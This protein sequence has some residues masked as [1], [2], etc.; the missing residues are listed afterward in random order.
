LNSYV[1][2]I[3]ISAAV[4]SPL[5]LNVYV[6]STISDI[7]HTKNTRTQESLGY[8]PGTSYIPQPS[9]VSFIFGTQ[10]IN[11]SECSRVQLSSMQRRHSVTAAAVAVAAASLLLSC[12]TCCLDSTPSVLLHSASIA[13]VLS[14]MSVLLTATRNVWKRNGGKPKRKRR[15]YEL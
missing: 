3:V 2:C 13:F 1:I 8:P 14:T 11:D 15:R 5:I 6:S 4:I 10:C 7:S 9:S 12:M